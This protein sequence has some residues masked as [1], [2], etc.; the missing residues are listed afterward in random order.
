M[1]KLTVFYGNYGSGKT[2]LALNFALKLKEC[3]RDVTLIDFDIV[4]P[5]FRSSEHAEM[6]RSKGIRVI[7]P[8]FANTQVDLPSLPAEV[9]SVF[10]GGYAVFDCG[11]DPVGATALGALKKRFDAVR[12]DLDALYVVNTRRPFQE[13]AQRILGE[14]EQIQKSSRLIADAFV[15][16][17]NIGAETTGAELKE[18]YE[19]IRELSSITNIPLRFVSGTSESLKTFRSLCPGYGGEMFKLDI[20]MRPEW[21]YT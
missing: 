2:E 1:K 7:A 3:Q 20:F 21:M 10:S 18:G 15:L 14:L 17:T 9:Y 12:C 11:G 16:N 8:Q 5:Y 13:N 6:L 4:N 19:I